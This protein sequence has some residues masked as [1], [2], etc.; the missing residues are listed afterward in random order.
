[1]LAGSASDAC[2]EIA[3]ALRDSGLPVVLV[4]GPTGADRSS[5]LDEI[6]LTL[7]PARVRRARARAYDVSPLGPVLDAFDVVAPDAPATVRRSPLDVP[8]LRRT[9]IVAGLVAEVT[10]LLGEQPSYLIVDDA[11]E[12]DAVTL[13]ALEQ[14]ARIEGGLLRLLLVVDGSRPLPATALLERPH[15]TVR[16]PDVPPTPSP[17][18]DDALAPLVRALTLLDG[19]ATYDELAAASGHG[20]LDLADVVE[21]ALRDG[22]VAEHDRELRLDRALLAVAERAIPASGRAAL[23]RDLGHR[24]LRA[25]L[26]LNR[27]A[28]Q[29]LRSGDAQDDEAA[30]TLVAVAEQVAGRAPDAAADLLGQAV[31]L[32]SRW[33]AVHVSAQRA[34]VDAL[35]WSGRLQESV[36]ATERLRA[37]TDPA[38]R[39]DAEE[40]AIRC[41]TILGRPGEALERALALPRLPGRTAWVEALTAV[42]SMLALDLTQA[43]SRADTALATASAEGD[44]LAAILA[45]SARG[46]VLNLL[47]HHQAATAPTAQA[48]A[49]AD[50]TPDGVGHR[51]APRLFLGLAQE[52]ASLGADARATLEEGLRT[53]DLTGTAWAVPFFH[54]ALGL[55]HLNAARLDAADDACRTGLSLA[56][57]LGI[58]LAAPWAHAVRGA[59]AL[60]V[61]DLQGADGHLVAGEQAIAAGGPQF[62]LDW[63]AWMRALHLEASADP[64]GAQALLR[65]AWE[66]AELANARSALTLF[67]P[68]LVRLSLGLGE[69]PTAQ[70]VVTRLADGHGDGRTNVDAHL[71]RCRGLVERDLDL[72]RRARE[73]HEAGDRPLDVLLDDEAEILVLLTMSRVDRALA[74]E[75]VAALLR[76]C[77]DLGLGLLAA[78]VRRTA[79]HLLPSSNGS[80]HRP[81]TGWDSLTPTERR[82]AAAVAAGRT[83]AEVAGELSTSVRT[84]ESHLYRTYT[85][86][87]VKNRTELALAHSRRPT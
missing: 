51:L 47:G 62:G 46:W 38:V 28:A 43:E 59:V 39:L 42:M 70:E 31:R 21:R 57:D 85:K 72:I 4:A 15:V 11:H 18:V 87:G 50:A 60:H 35:F 58:A 79:P 71:D 8:T 3:G 6:A 81:A 12:A 33:S 37:E 5:L 29:F 16:L 55:A 1:M 74:A 75:R 25:G 20:A 78:R 40:T 13:A 56:G 83:N 34:L 68:D 48:V 2:A 49:L 84:V 10:G 32:S 27:V 36:A 77:D 24:L 82:V 61:G 76:R 30:E 19:H 26:P 9:E 69:R 64:A 14:L 80:A 63:L 86:L 67:G 17:A 45:L 22:V 54:Y 65:G 23:H 41:L 53:T 44:D 66:A 52:S 73:V 7:A